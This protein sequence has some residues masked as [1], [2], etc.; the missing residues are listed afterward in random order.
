M[1]PQWAGA[2]WRDIDLVVEEVIVALDCENAAF[3]SFRSWSGCQDAA[4]ARSDRG[5][6]GCIGEPFPGKNGRSTF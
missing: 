2:D 3:R 1:N 5:F 6:D 4:R